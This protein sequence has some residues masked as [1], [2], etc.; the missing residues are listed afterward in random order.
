MPPRNDMDGDV[1][2]E[3]NSSGGTEARIAVMN[4]MPADIDGT[5][6]VGFRDPGKKTTFR[7]EEW[8]ITDEDYH[9]EGESA[10]GEADL[11]QNDTMERTFEVGRQDFDVSVWIAGDEDIVYAEIRSGF[12][13]AL[14]GDAV[15]SLL[16]DID[17]RLSAV[18][19]KEGQREAEG[20]DSQ[21]VPPRPRSAVPEKDA[22]SERRDLIGEA[23]K[24]AAGDI[25]A[26][27]L[28][29]S[30]GALL[31]QGSVQT[32]AAIAGVGALLAYL[33]YRRRL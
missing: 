26:V 20:S 17:K 24:N 28:I 25:G 21:E 3:P 1:R 29:S 13:Q 31:Q 15:E 32:G 4:A 5:V 23:E 7:T 14:R 22:P 19:E 6:L 30:G 12:V 2:S 8:E 27:G 10:F 16:V 18:E 33:K 11:E 9:E